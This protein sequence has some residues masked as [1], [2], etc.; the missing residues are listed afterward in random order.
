MSIW[1]CPQ[2]D[3]TAVSVVDS[4][5]SRLREQDTIRRRRQCDECAHRWTTYEF[6]IGSNDLQLRLGWLSGD[7]ADTIRSCEKAIKTIRGNNGDDI[8]ADDVGPVQAA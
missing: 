7:L 3:G 4:R 2:C 8:Q 6:H 5:R 1:K